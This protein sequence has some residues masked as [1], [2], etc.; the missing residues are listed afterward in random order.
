LS[1]LD[2]RR[3]TT[4]LDDGYHLSFDATHVLAQYLLNSMCNRIDVRELDM[5]EVYTPPSPLTPMLGH[6]WQPRWRF[7]KPKNGDAPAE[8]KKAR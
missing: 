6:A 8:K 5:G 4:L 3:T 2:P 7:N 1:Q